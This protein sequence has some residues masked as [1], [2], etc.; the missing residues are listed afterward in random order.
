M[1]FKI[2][3]CQMAEEE[4]KNK[5]RN[6][7]EAM[8]GQAAQAGAK[9]VVLPEMW[10]CPYSMDCFREYGETEDG[11]TIAL[12]SRLAALQEITLIGGSIPEIEGDKVYNTCYV[13]GPDGKLLGKHRKAH[14][15]DIDIKGGIYFKESEV[16]TAGSCSTTV[17]TEFCKVGIA[18]CYDVRFPEMIRKMALSGAKLIVLPAAFNMTTGPAHWHLTMRARALDN[19]VYFAA[20]AP[21]RKEGGRY[22]A[23]GHSLVA[24]PWGEIIAQADE[25]E[26]ILYCDIDTDFVDTIRS[27]LP[28]LKH[29][30]EELY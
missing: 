12:L 9:M 14:L 8:I 3:L 21:A 1:K 11:E 7:M 22:T 24:D 23:Y 17:D 25:K 26:Q 27:Q 18:I 2:A 10:N 5:A 16:L 30:R 4:D 13:F 19:Q 29:R 6:K 20:A 15:F 28:L